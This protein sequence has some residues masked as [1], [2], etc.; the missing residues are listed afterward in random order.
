[1]VSTIKAASSTLSKYH[2]ERLHRCIIYPV[3]KIGV[4]FWNFLKPFLDKSITDNIVMLPGPSCGR[5]APIPR[6][7]M[8]EYLNEAVI[9]VLEARRLDLFNPKN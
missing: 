6:E 7:E 2:P 3:P 9:D 8:K 5:H 1:M 4:I